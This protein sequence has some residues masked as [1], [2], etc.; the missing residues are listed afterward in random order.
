MENLISNYFKDNSENIQIV[1][2]MNKLKKGGNQ[3]LS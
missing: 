2:I 3:V 1:N